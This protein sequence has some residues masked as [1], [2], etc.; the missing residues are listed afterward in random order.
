MKALL[1][2]LRRA[3]MAD[4]LL[5]AVRPEHFRALDDPDAQRRLFAGS[6]RMVEVEVHSFCNRRCWFCPNAF[7]D[8]HSTTSYLDEAV[9]RRLLADLGEIGW[10][11]VLSFSRYSEPFADEVFYARLRQAREALPK[12]LLHTNTNGDYLTDATLERAARAGLDRLYVQLYL[13]RDEPFDRPHVTAHAAALLKRIP[14]ASLREAP[15]HAGWIGWKGAFGR[16]QMLMYARDFRADGVNRCGIDVAR[17]AGR[18]APCLRPFAEAYVDYNAS[19]VP[20]CNLRS[21]YPPHVS[22]VWG[23]IDA[24]PGSIFRVFAGARAAAWR[25]ALIEF[26]PKPEACRN[27]TFDPIDDTRPNRRRIARIAAG[28][29]GETP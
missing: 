3:L 11:G 9:Y 18:T 21:D 17:N 14:S 24:T 29:S 2:K 25:R 12:A 27:C 7:I 28:T 4:P 16:I 15:V 19:V 6:V 10:N 26:G 20:C 5:R 22:A 13:D 8:R 23:T 1:K